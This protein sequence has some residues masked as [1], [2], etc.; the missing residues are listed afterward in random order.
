MTNNQIKTNVR[1]VELGAKK[2]SIHKVKLVDQSGTYINAVAKAQLIENEAF[3]KVLL[4]THGESDV[5]VEVTLVTSEYKGHTNV[6]LNPSSSR[7]DLNALK[8][9]LLGTK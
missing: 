7:M 3:L 1:L 9:K 8:A 6:W 5:F 4:T 2:D